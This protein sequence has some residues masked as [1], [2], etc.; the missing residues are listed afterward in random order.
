MRSVMKIHVH[1]ADKSAFFPEH[2]N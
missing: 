1:K 2:I